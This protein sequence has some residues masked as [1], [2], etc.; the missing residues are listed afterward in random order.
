MKP[1][2]FIH[3]APTTTAEAL[4]LLAAV[5]ED[6]KVLA[7]GQ[8]LIPLMNF[9]LA[10][11]EHLVDINGLDELDTVRVDAA[12]VVVGARVRHA[13]LEHHA[14]AYG[15]CGLLR[16]ALVHVAH[17]VIR[18]RG[19]VCGSL[20]HADP[21]GELTAVLAVLG[22]TVTVAAAGTGGGEPTRRTVAAAD[23][24][25]GP[26]EADVRPDEL[27]ESAAFPR[28]GPGAGSAF[29]EVARRHGDYA[30]CGVA[31]VLEA[32]EQ[33]QVTAA[34]LGFVSVGPV[35]VVVDLTGDLGGSLLDDRACGR[36]AEVARAAVQPAG[37]LHASADYRRHLAGVLAQRALRA[38]AAERSERAQAAGRPEADEGQGHDHGARPAPRLPERLRLPV[39]AGAG[40]AG[41]PPVTPEPAAGAGEERHA[42]E[43]VV[44]GRRMAA[45]VPARRLLSD[46]LR[47]DL[48]LTGTHVGCEHGVCG[49]CTVL[50]DGA[51][52]RSCLAFAVGV[53]GSEILTVEALAEQDGTL[54]PVQ[55]A[56][57]DCHG[58]Q[59]GFCTPGFLMS[60]VGL[61]A[62]NPDPS[63]DEILEGISG[64]LCRCTGYQNIRAAVRRAADL[65]AVDPDG[66]A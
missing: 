42:V 49:C 33:N 45:A 28:L 1:S 26:L 24:F 54:H 25:L 66:A 7:G 62:A 20:A 19:T 65:L 30:I 41:P 2:A 18:S 53:A 43:M 57:A 12:A 60:T 22:G 55:Q 44:N 32:D 4:D 38:A 27:V 35:P 11:P 5:G 31:A 47:H 39:P 9:R 63:D 51:P 13:A 40:T 15:A 17:P 61:L 58:L 29:V 46:F 14:G 56:Y 8:S 10:V 64:N 3:H 16:Q 23:F 50:L 21:S 59:C 6:G 37:D 48:G 34:R 36:A 52:V